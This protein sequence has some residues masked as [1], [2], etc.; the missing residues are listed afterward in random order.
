MTYFPPSFA[1][2]RTKEGGV[3]LYTG[4]HSVLVSQFKDKPLIIINGDVVGCEHGCSFP[5]GQMQA[6]FKWE[7]A[8]FKPLVSR[9]SIC[10]SCHYNENLTNVKNPRH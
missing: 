3:K 4:G 9:K 2:L 6:D 5:E 8:F 10:S 7:T 1:V